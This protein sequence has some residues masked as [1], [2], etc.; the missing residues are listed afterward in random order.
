MTCGKCGATVAQVSGKAGG[1]YGCLAATKGSCDNRLLVRRK[2]AEKIIIEA[3]QERLSSVEHI[4]YVLKR[5]EGEVCKLYA[6]VPETVRLK[7]TE[8]AIEERRLANFVDFIGEGRGSRSLAQALLETE[9]KVESLKETLDGLRRSRDK[10]FQAPPVEWIE[11]RLSQMKEVL[12][13][14]VERSGLILRKLLG[15]IRLEPTHGNIGRPY[16]VATTSLNTLALLEEPQESSSPEGGA[17]SLRWWRRR[18]S[19]YRP[20]LWRLVPN[21]P[22]SFC[23]G[24]PVSAHQPSLWSN[25]S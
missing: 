2:L 17:N 14:S 3:V 10:V 9:Q 1:Y 16:Y 6:H 19:N 5:V 25:R 8:L 23:T 7:E 18:E 13:R 15:R 4:Q 24:P 12:D 21:S 11:E 20:P 22:G